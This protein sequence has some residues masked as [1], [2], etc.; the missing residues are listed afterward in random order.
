MHNTVIHMHVNKTYI[1]STPFL[2]QE[3]EIHRSLVCLTTVNTTYTHSYTN[4]T[5]LLV[6]F[7]HTLVGDIPL[8]KCD[9]LCRL[10][11]A[12]NGGT[13]NQMNLKFQ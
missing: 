2:V 9:E 10:K 5:F 1:Q 4:N 3:L 7:R 13:T 6:G 8:L 11:L 12:R